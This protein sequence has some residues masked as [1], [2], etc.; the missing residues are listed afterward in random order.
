MHHLSNIDHIEQFHDI[1]G[2]SL[3]LS[4]KKINTGF[5]TSA[6]FFMNALASNDWPELEITGPGFGIFSWS[7]EGFI[8]IRS[9]YEGKSCKSN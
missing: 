3:E 2:I 7:G 9:L 5:L 6:I 1:F 8:Y 4:R